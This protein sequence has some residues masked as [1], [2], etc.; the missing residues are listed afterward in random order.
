[1]SHTH[2]EKTAAQPEPSA[3][4]R[5]HRVSQRALPSESTPA[6]NKYGS[7]LPYVSAVKTFEQVREH[8]GN[9]MNGRF[10]GA[11]PVNTFFDTFVPAVEELSPDLSDNPFAMVPID[12]AE[13]TLYDPFVSTRFIG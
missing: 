10:V 7:N 3:T 6:K 1:M 12:G 8:L 13:S 2:Q 4:P 9:E 5:P 11:M